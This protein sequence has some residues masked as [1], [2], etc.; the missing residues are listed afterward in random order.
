MKRLKYFFLITDIGF[1]VYWFI[2]IC[3]MIPQEYLFKDYQNPILVAWNWSFLPLDLLISFTGFVS[4][5]LYYKHKQIWSH[6][7]FLSLILTFCSGLQALVFWTIRLDFDVSWWI[8]NLYLLLYPCFFLK[9]IW[10]ECG[11]YAT[12]MR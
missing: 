3:H 10:R 7:A 4:L 12:N 5:Y 2:T 11:W 1:I 8:P 9:G 6:F